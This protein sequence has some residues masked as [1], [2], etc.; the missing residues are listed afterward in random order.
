MAVQIPAAL[1]CGCR[2]VVPLRCAQHIRLDGVRQDRTRRYIGG[3]STHPTLINHKADI[4]LNAF[5][6]LSY[7]VTP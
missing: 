2:S 7:A 6:E 5:L 4:P 1:C 3:H